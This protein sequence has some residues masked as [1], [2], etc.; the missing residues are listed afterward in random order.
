[1]DVRPLSFAEGAKAGVMFRSEDPTLGADYY[2]TISVMPSAQQIRLEAWHGGEWAVW[3]FQEIPGDLIPQY[4][5]YKL[6][7]DC[8]A[9]SIRVYLSGKLAAEFTSSV[10][11]GAGYFGLTI[12]SSQTPQSVTFDNLVITEHP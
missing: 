5:I 9:D 4:G 1:V 7:I 2:Y 8:Q 10:I 6:K 3:E 11:Q 12:V